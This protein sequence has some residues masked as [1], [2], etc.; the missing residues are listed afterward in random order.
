MDQVFDS[1]LNQVGSLATLVKGDPNS[2][3]EPTVTG[4]STISIKV[5][6][7]SLRED[8]DIKTHGKVYKVRKAAYI[9]YRT[10]IQP[11]DFLYLGEDKYLVLGVEDESGRQHHLKL[12]IYKL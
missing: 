2:F 5:A 11:G 1:L 10:D 3:G 9:H 4:E 7:S 8:L 6:V 12:F